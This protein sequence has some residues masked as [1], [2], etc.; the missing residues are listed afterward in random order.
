MTRR[1]IALAVLTAAAIADCGV[2]GW[3]VLLAFVTSDPAAFSGWLAGWVIVMVVLTVLAV[4]PYGRREDYGLPQEADPEKHLAPLFAP[5]PGEDTITTDLRQRR[6]LLRPRGLSRDMADVL[7][8]TVARRTERLRELHLPHHDSAPEDVPGRSLQRD[9]PS[10][11]A[12]DS[13]LVVRVAG[14]HRGQRKNRRRPEFSPAPALGSGPVAPVPAAGTDYRLVRIEEDDGP[15][16]RAIERDLAERYPLEPGAAPGDYDWEIT[17][18]EHAAARAHLIEHHGEVP[19]SLQRVED[20][21][22]RF[23]GPVNPDLCPVCECRVLRDGGLHCPACGWL[24]PGSDIAA[25][26]GADPDPCTCTCQ[27]MGSH[28]PDCGVWGPPLEPPDAEPMLAAPLPD[29]PADQD[30]PGPLYTWKTGEF[31]RDMLAEV[32]GETA[33]AS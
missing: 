31:S 13:V 16:Y 33:A 29:L 22:G 30:D 4:Y 32:L 10:G 9:C 18:D 20:L 12:G 3:H 15:D 8:A 26:F 21:G 17:E 14:R 5:H 27:I 19:A 24:E 23:A 11:S 25:G 6:M 7:A 28:D 1:A 2:A